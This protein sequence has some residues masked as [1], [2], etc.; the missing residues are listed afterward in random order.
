MNFSCIA[1]DPSRS[2]P[3]YP[4]DI[5]GF[6]IPAR[7]GERMYASLLRPQGLGPHPTVLLLHGYPGDENNGD[8]AHVFQRFGCAVVVFHYRGT[9]GSEGR[10]SLCHVLEDVE[11]TLRFLRAHS[12]EAEFPFD[13]DRIFLIGHSMGGFAALETAARDSGLLGTAALAAFDFSLTAGKPKLKSAVRK[14]FADCPP[15]RR[16]GLDALMCEIDEHAQDWHFPSLAKGL[17]KRPLLLIGGTLDPI[18]RPEHHFRPL[19]RAMEETEG[20]DFRTVL[21]PDGHCLCENRVR[22]ARELTQWMS[23]LLGNRKK[24]AR[25]KVFSADCASQ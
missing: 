24:I 5:T 19:K 15:I 12:G 23:E 22:L 1:A 11:D 3:E 16:I 10:F 14:E 9:W 13:A 6:V 8:L 2:C 20:A 21:Y 25:A 4:A 18:S 7:G 17:S